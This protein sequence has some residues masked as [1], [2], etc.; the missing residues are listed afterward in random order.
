MGLGELSGSV[1]QGSSAQSSWNEAQSQSWSAT[2]A[3]AAREWS[4]QQAQIAR[5]W[6]EAMLQK[7]MDYNALE[8]EK[9]RS[10]EQ[11]N[12]DIANEMA[13]TVYTRAAKNMQEAGINPILAYTAG[14]G[15]VGSGATSGGAAATSS[16]PS[17]A[18]GQSFMDQN[19]AS[20]TYSHGKS[21]G[22]SWQESESGLATGLQLMGEALGNAIKTMN[23][24]NTINFAMDKLSGGA[25]ATWEDIKL[26]MIDNLPNNIVK[27]L[28]LNSDQSSTKGEAPKRKKNITGST[29]DFNWTLKN[30]V[31][32][33]K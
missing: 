17:G 4:A 25:K 26:L 3:Q 15:G 18:M 29:R 13:N 7:Q 1:S 20:S 11:G 5:E 2:Q 16:L 9:Q 33:N 27:F 21:S 8:A 28:G 6:Q 10:W 31:L 23:T 32:G 24:G 12:I 30:G 22:S 19:S 14:L